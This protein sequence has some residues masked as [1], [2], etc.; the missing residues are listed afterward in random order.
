MSSGLVRQNEDAP[1]TAAQTGA[2]P[3]APASEQATTEE[4]YGLVREVIAPHL[5]E[6]ARCRSTRELA[7]N[8]T[9]R[10]LEPVVSR[11]LETPEVGDLSWAAPPPQTAYRF[12]AWNL[13]RGIE[14]EGQIDALRSHPYL[15]E[16][17]VLL[18][19]ETDPRPT[20]RLG[21]AP[22]RFSRG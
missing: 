14:L 3:S 21:I 15:R 6:L 18:L 17:D 22:A 2:G 7:D 16:A 12:V 8:Q 20:P 1:P 11:V 4:I 5:S 10:R 9:Y 19:T 13:E